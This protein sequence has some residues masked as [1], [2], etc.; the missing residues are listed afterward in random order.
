MTS[1]GL[2]VVRALF[3]DG[4]LSNITVELFRPPITRLFMG[5][6]PDVVAKTVPYL[7][8]LC[9]H[10]QRT[11]AQAALAAAQDELPR[12]ADSHE[13]W[14][15]VLHENLW[16]LLLDWPP[17]LGLPPEKDAFIAWRNGRHNDDC[18]EK[19]QSLL[20]E[21]LRPLA[22]KCLEKLVDPE[23]SCCFYGRGN[24]D[25]SPAPALLPQPWLDY[26]QG[27]TA[28][29]PA[30]PTPPSI[31][32]VYRARLV[33]VETAV[34][35]LADAAPFPVAAAGGEGWGVAQALTARGVL[36]HAVHLD[37]GKV[38]NYRVQAPTDSFFADAAALSSLLASLQFDS[39]DQAR[40]A[41]NRAI[42]ALDPCLPYEVE[43]QN[44]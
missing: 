30:P 33:E 13:L 32:A 24:H 18:L 15:E 25:I 20:A 39:L 19:T 42:L 21:T 1:A 6:L 28:Q 35:A 5:Q 11:V 36:T 43:L 22:E 2:L 4:R 14:L 31:S 38:V 34:K 17:A 23:A 9:A 7:Y 10:A 37:E 16:R 27:T 26:W 29:M 12:P 3:K 41:L 8:T 40:Q 44:A